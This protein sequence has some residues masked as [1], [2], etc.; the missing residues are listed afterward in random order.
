MLDTTAHACLFVCVFVCLSSFLF[1]CA[2]TSNT[3]WNQIRFYSVTLTKLTTVISL[4]F[5][6]S[7]DSTKILEIFLKRSKNVPSN[8]LNKLINKYFWKLFT[9]ILVTSPPIVTLIFYTPHHIH[10]N[11][12]KCHLAIPRQ[13]RNF[14]T[15]LMQV[16]RVWSPCNYLN[17]GN[18][19]LKLLFKNPPSKDSPTWYLTIS[20]GLDA[21]IWWSCFV[22]HQYGQIYRFGKRLSSA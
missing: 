15:S 19:F 3:C 7:A 8:F 1:A 4:Y 6:L 22:R 18:A 20:F 13:R 5:L 11:S 9:I 12:L 2:L 17:S 14:L 10:S 16:P 21:W